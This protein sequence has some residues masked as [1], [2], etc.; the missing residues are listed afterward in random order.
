MSFSNRKSLINDLIISF[1]VGQV[2]LLPL[3]IVMMA[4]A[5]PASFSTWAII[6]IEF[7][8]LLIIFFF[9][10]LIQKESD[11]NFHNWVIL[12]LVDLLPFAWIFEPQKLFC[13]RN[14]VR[15]PYIISAVCIL[16]G[17][18]F[19]LESNHI[20]RHFVNNK[21][22]IKKLFK[23]LY[24]GFICHFIFIS[25]SVL[26]CLFFNTKFFPVILG[27]LLSLIFLIVV[28]VIIFAC[29]IDSFPI[30][31][32]VAILSLCFCIFII[33]PFFHSVGQKFSNTVLQFY[34][35]F[36]ASF[37][38]FGAIIGHVVY[39]KKFAYPYIIL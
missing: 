15:H 9:F 13:R 33:Y 3:Y 4:S 31:L 25:C 6:I 5:D 36:Y 34:K 29:S 11:W 28:A 21:R 14:E 26:I 18:V 22:K 39:E 10:L 32:G 7:M 8:L 16:I 37:Y 19:G 24:P 38:S 35:I 23:E 1:F 30:I 17:I 20:K 12:F 27:I 2:L